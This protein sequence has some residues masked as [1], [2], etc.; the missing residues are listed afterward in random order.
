[1]IQNIIK[2]FSLTADEARGALKT[3]MAQSAVPTEKEGLWAKLRR[4][5]T[6]TGN[7]EP[8]KWTPA[9]TPLGP[10]REGAAQGQT[11][12]APSTTGAPM[13]SFNPRTANTGPKKQGAGSG[14]GDGGGGPSGVFLGGAGS[15]K[16][17]SGDGFDEQAELEKQRNDD[18]DDYEEEIPPEILSVLEEDKF[19]KEVSTSVYQHQ[20]ILSPSYSLFHSSVNIR[21]IS[22]MCYYCRSH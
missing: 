8:R 7:V 16:S 9:D 11:R 18:D 22:I 2:P 19:L 5:S 12:K 1:M 13:R 6:P 17:R 3:F 20:N 10:G 21:L 15:K 14:G 4:D